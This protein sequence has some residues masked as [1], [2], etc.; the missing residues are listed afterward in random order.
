VNLPDKV[1]AKLQTLPDKPGVYFMRDR[2]GRVIYVG[3]A[4]SLRDRVRQYFQ[5]G[6]LRSAAPK[7][8]GLIRA[9]HDLDFLVVRNEAD[10]LLTESKF[11]KE[12]RPRYNSYFKDDKRFMLLRVNLRDPFP[13]FS[14]CR[15][16]RD[17]GSLYFGPYVTP[18]S[19]RVAKDYI[20][21][22][23]GLRLCLP[24]TP[25]PE[26][27]RHCLNDIIRFCSAPCLGRIDEAGYRA[28]VEAACAFLR[29]DHPEGLQE[30]ED[31]MAAA[32][33]GL[34]FEQAAEYRDLLWML[35]A[36]VK[37]RA[38][39]RSSLGIR[40]ED[41]RR[42]VR[43]LQDALGLAGPPRVIECFDISNISGTHAVGSMVCSVDGLP[44]RNRYRLFRIKT[45]EGADDPGM[46]AEVIRRRYARVKEEGG[47]P[48]D[49]VL[50]DGGIT[51][52]RA[53]RAELDALGWDAVPTAG[54]AKRFEEIYRDSGPRAAPLRLPLDSPA[55]KV[56]QRIRD[57][58]HRFALTYHRKLRN[59]RL[60]ESILDDIPGLGGKRK[61][62]LLRRFGSVAR[63]RRASAEQ[64]AELPGIRK[65]L[66]LEIIEKIGK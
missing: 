42:G 22:K 6:T 11:I 19:A 17:D 41:A 59:R 58:A 24:R 15:I 28:R 51:Q 14:L 9:I 4:L 35:R 33:A 37:Q 25:G 38:S 18:G 61:Q 12:Y 44:Q 56:L 53:A 57:E 48:P 60:K 55:L 8:R 3:K 1:K 26:D 49:L 27:H 36:V 30:I 52:L 13:R 16:A 63:L 5:R 54:L 2:A 66:A 65:P 29:G 10:A 64:I 43:E 32:S 47:A 21:K 20:E 23:F 31:R 7:I 50:V 46:M 39:G 62:L 40:S 34:D 45:V